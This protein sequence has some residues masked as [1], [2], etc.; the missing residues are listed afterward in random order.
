M[1]DNVVDIASK[2]NK[3]SENGEHEN[4][5]GHCVWREST[6]NNFINKIK[7]LDATS[8]AYYVQVEDLIG[9]VEYIN[10]R[11]TLSEIAGEIIDEL[12][13]EYGE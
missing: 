2:R 10:R 4:V 5:C 13:E 1:N 12:N 8:D 3:Q 6:I 9:Y 11:N 7:E